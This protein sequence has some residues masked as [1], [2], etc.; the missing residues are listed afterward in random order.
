MIKELSNFL[1]DTDKYKYLNQNKI[2]AKNQIMA[3]DPFS[4]RLIPFE[5]VLII[6]YYYVRFIGRK[7]TI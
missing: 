4:D 5:K 6:E 3:N 7:V 2:I 1:Y